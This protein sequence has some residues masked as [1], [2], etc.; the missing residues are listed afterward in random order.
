MT[1]PPIQT[2]ATCSGWGELTEHANDGTHGCSHQWDRTYVC[3]DCRGTGECPAETD[4]SATSILR[5]SA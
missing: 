5:D 2:C 1:L 4:P 3:R